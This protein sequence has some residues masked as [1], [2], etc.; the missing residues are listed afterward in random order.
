MTG[1]SKPSTATSVTNKAANRAPAAQIQQRL[2][3]PRKTSQDNLAK[4]TGASESGVKLSSKAG[5]GTR[6]PAPRSKPVPLQETKQQVEE[7]TSGQQYIFSMEAVDT[8]VRR[9]R[10]QIRDI[11]ECCKEETQLLSRLTFT[12]LNK[13][14]N[15]DLNAPLDESLTYV[16]MDYVFALD[17]L[18]ERKMRAMSELRKEVKALTVSNQDARKQ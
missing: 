7:T 15:M 8:F 18:L 1:T 9:H 10:Q 6:L 13:Q 3:T 5:P 14:Q 11:T 12:G 17:G 4:S 16:F 2:E